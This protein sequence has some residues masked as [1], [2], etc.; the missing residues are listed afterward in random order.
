MIKLKYV[1]AI[2]LVYLCAAIFSTGH[3]HPDE[4]YQILE[5]AAYKLHLSSPSGLTWEFYAQIRST[6]Q[7]C[8]VIYLYKMMQLFTYPYNS[9]VL[10][11]PF[12]VTCITRIFAAGLSVYAA[13]LF[14]VRF[15]CELNNAKLKKWLVLLSF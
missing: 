10:V 8:G 4:Y 13:Y 2:F 6:I 1:Y 9:G 3:M 5:F 14:I 15:G 12:I 11:N 7:A